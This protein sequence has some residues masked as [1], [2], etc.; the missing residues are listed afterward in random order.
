MRSQG[1]ICDSVAGLSPSQGGLKDGGLGT[2]SREHSMPAESIV[3]PGCV[4]VPQRGH[5]DFPWDRSV[6]LQS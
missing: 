3:A 6:C 5:E 1:L 2:A 4:S